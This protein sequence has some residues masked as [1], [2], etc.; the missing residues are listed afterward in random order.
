M[1]RFVALNQ[2]GSGWLCYD[3]FSQVRSVLSG[4]VWAR[5]DKL[6]QISCGKLG[7]VL[8]SLIGLGWFC[9][10]WFRQIRRV[11]SRYVGSSQIC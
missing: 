3:R 5:F 2:M 7:W 9:Y 8:L 11:A 6:S 4:C 1:F 10:D